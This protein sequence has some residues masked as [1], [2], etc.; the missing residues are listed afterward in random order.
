MRGM[1][2]F[3]P[4]N[5][6]HDAQE[7]L[8]AALA[9]LGTADFRFDLRQSTQCCT[10][11]E[12]T[13]VSERATCLQI[14][15]DADDLSVAAGLRR[16][17][18]PEWMNGADK[19]HCEMCCSQ[20]EAKKWTQFDSLP[21]LLVLQLSVQRDS[22]NYRKSRMKAPLRL[23]VGKDDETFELW[24]VI[25]HAGLAVNSGH[26]F[27]LVKTSNDAW[28][29]F[30]DENTTQLSEA[31]VEEQ[32]G[33]TTA[34]GSIAPYLLFYRRADTATVVDVAVKS[35][36]DSENEEFEP[37]RIVG[38]I[39][40]E[41]KRV[42]LMKW[43]GWDNED[44]SLEDAEKV[45]GD[46]VFRKVL[47][48]FSPDFMMVE[49]T[50]HKT[51]AEEM[52][53]E[54][55]AGAQAPETETTPAISPAISTLGGDAV[56]ADPAVESTQENAAV[57]AVAKVAPAAAA[58]EAAAGREEGRV[59]AEVVHATE[60]QSGVLKPAR[61]SGVDRD[62]AVESTRLLEE[63]WL[64]YS[65][66]PDADESEQYDIEE[67]PL[68]TESDKESTTVKGKVAAGQE[69]ARP[70]DAVE[71]ANTQPVPGVEIANTIRGT[72]DDVI[73]VADCVSRLVAST[74]DAQQQTLPHSTVDDIEIVQS[75]DEV[76]DDDCIRCSAAGCNSEAYIKHPLLSVPMCF[77]C[78]GLC[79]PVIQGDNG[80][81]VWCGQVADTMDTKCR[82]EVCDLRFC[83]GCLSKNLGTRRAMAITQLAT[84]RDWICLACNASELVHFSF[85]ADQLAESWLPQKRKKRSRNLPENLSAPLATELIPPRKQR[86]A[87]SAKRRAE[88][89][90]TAQPSRTATAI[91]RGAKRTKPP[92]VASA[93]AAAGAGYPC[94]YAIF[95]CTTIPKNK[96]SEASHACKS[97][98]FK[99]C[100]GALARRHE[101]D[102]QLAVAENQLIGL[103]SNGVKVEKNPPCCCRGT[104]DCRGGSGRKHTNAC[105]TLNPHPKFP[106]PS[107]ER[108]QPA[109][110]EVQSPAAE[111]TGRP[112]HALPAGHR[113]V[114][115]LAELRAGC[116]VVVQ[117]DSVEWKDVWQYVREED[118]V[119][120]VG[121]L[122]RFR[123]G[124]G[125]RSGVWAAIDF[126]PAGFTTPARSFSLTRLAS[127]GRLGVAGPLPA[128]GR[129]DSLMPRRKRNETK[130]LLPASAKMARYRRPVA[131]SAAAGSNVAPGAQ[132]SEPAAG[133]ASEEC[134]ICLEA[135][136]EGEFRRGR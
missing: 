18:A 64:P 28:T 97:C 88:Q 59:E 6:Q 41:G 136:A 10:C 120:H 118:N 44:P 7:F 8:A 29:K 57:A 12:T 45:K 99:G 38:C 14:A 119:W 3:A 135:P 49:D 35:A 54:K 24:A 23:D 131:Q 16:L 105:L 32:L 55:V 123:R 65:V 79:A 27:C 4:R 125:A 62:G 50:R 31:R 13:S 26:Y 17:L 110:R 25:F 103:S 89:V 61:Q 20:Q 74:V 40:K 78:H 106:P 34:V 46:F 90:P 91:K 104:L 37:D 116:L 22:F 126:T 107:S 48:D 113:L 33:S 15:S 73:E 52:Q 9:T 132:S 76:L 82:I 77:D 98:K 133:V 87:H 109:K 85:C 134:G 84:H 19:Y 71:A 114:A 121:R 70:A 117:W 124:S 129:A 108:K 128:P 100:G 58:G 21:P 80:H 93:A 66:G 102:A 51:T 43:K 112:F 69:V 86:A 11:E 67:V 95:G 60:A 39:E 130:P 94:R 127:R 75:P 36:G 68:D 56:L 101:L 42:Y 111:T 96:S 5:S 53:V 1:Q 63:A 81:C 47:L 122:G 72:I 83:S 115:D 92:L 30:D 2:Q